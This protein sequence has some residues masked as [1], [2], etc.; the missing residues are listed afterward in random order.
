MYRVAQVK[1]DFSSLGGSQVGLGPP[2]WPELSFGD[3]KA[4]DLKPAHGYDL[5]LQKR[6]PKKMAKISS[7]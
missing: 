6:P 5:S 4:T 1:L 7:M 2:L 3:L